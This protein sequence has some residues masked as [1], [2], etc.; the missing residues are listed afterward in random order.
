M[1]D[2][3]KLQIGAETYNL[4]DSTARQTATAA[5]EAAGQAKTT[6]GQAQTAANSAASAANSA[7]S[8]ALQGFKVAFTSPDTIT[9]TQITE[10]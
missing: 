2:V 6:A 5:S 3:S 8:L 1:A 4:S 7:K 9:F 10:G